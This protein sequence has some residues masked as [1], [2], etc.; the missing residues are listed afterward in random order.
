M[1]NIFRS[2]TD[3]KILHASGQPNSKKRAFITF[4][5]VEDAQAAFAKSNGL[6]VNNHLV[7]VFYARHQETKVDVKPKKAATPAVQKKIVPKVA[8]DSSGDDS[9][10]VASS[11]EGIQEVEEEQPKQKKLVK[12]VISNPDYFKTFIFT[13]YKKN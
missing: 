10:E 7:D 13:F 11:D 5:T 9:E 8:A 4:G 3:I 6:K 12:K 2:S 1:K